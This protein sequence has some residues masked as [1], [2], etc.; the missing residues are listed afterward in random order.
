MRWL[1]LHGICIG[2]S[3][4]A[5][6]DALTGRDPAPKAPAAPGELSVGE[7]TRLIP[8]AAAIP[9]EVLERFVTDPPLTVSGIEDHRLTA[10]VLAMDPESAADED[11]R[12]H[13]DFRYT[14]LPQPPPQMILKAVRTDR[15][16]ATIIRPEYIVDCTC[17]SEGDRAEGVVAFR[18]PGVYEGQ[19]E[20]TARRTEG[21]WAVTEFR[22]PAY[23][24]ATRR[25]SDG[26]WQLA[27]EPLL[28]GS[29]AS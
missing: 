25:T 26:T 9:V 10:L 19:V 23:R 27:T 11:D 15:G 20:F 24:L 4:T 21:R 16:H 2:I 1:V 13:G 6:C 29:P 7:A 12:V 5:G 3:L 22:M 18:A 17:Q 14:P 8:A 28:A